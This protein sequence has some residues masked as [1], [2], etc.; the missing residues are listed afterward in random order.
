MIDL[1]VHSYRSDGTFSPSELVDYAKE[2]GLHAFA[3]TDHDTVDGLDEALSYAE[4]LKEKYTDVP[5]VIPGIEFSTEYE[6]KDVH[7]LG[8]FIDYKAPVFSKYLKDFVESRDNRNIKMCKSLQQDNIDISYEELVSSFPGAVI[9]RAHFA[10]LLQEKG[11][12][13]SREEAFEKY[14]GDRSK[15]YIPREKVTPEKAIDLILKADGVPVL[16]HPILYHLSDSKLDALVSRLKKQGLIGIEAIYSTYSP[17]EERQ[18]RRLAQKYHLLLS[19]GSD[20]HGSNKNNIDLGTGYGKLYVPDDLLTKL[21]AAKKNILFTDMDG[22]LLLQDSTISDSMLSALQKATS[23]GHKIVLTSGRPLPSIKE[24]IVKLGLNFSNTF[25]IANNG[26]LIYDFDKDEIIYDKRIPFDLCKLICEFA[27]ENDVYVQGFTED[28]LVTYKE[29]E[30]LTFYCKKIKINT[31]L[32]QNYK[33]LFKNGA[34][35][36]HFISLTDHSK[37]ES[38]RA[39]LLDKYGNC[40]EAFFSNDY[41]LEIVPKG[42][43]KG[44]AVRFMEEYLPHI[45][46]HTFAA[47]DEENDISML[48]AAGI[49][50]AVANAKEPVKE[51]ARIVTINDN[52]HDGLLEILEKYFA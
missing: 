27:E 32:S 22:T 41:Y 43:N 1:H 29:T 4:K 34:Y 9:T 16:A 13:K 20:F 48:E 5:R 36:F 2:K 51:K 10:K 30:E 24:R 7:I 18:I 8:L 44:S 12:V 45:H 47:G 26:S 35:K 15:H 3:L 39:L 11:Y 38:L 23:N 49:S 31:I 21:E 42:I 37:L 33:E 6:G 40:L 46:S 19:G 50:V 14:I 28:N 25:V 52:N 17:S